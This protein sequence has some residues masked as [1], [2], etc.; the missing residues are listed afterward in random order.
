MPPNHVCFLSLWVYFFIYYT[1]IQFYLFIFDS[2]GSLLLLCHFSPVEVSGATL[3]RGAWAPHC[4]DFSCCGSRTPGHAG[5]S[6]CSLWAQDVTPYF[7][8]Q[9]QWLWPTGSVALQHAGSS[10]TWDW[11]RV[12]CIGRWILYHW[13]TKEAQVYFLNWLLYVTFDFFQTHRNRDFW[14][15]Q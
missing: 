7:G 12:S 6:S 9:A 1:Y 11:T 14:N 4:S 2:V 5:C 3:C 10:W 15:L 13:A 8:A